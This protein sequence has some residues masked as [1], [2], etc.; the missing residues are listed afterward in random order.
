LYLFGTRVEGRANT[1]SDLDIGILTGP[2]VPLSR[3]W[4]LEDDWTAQWPET[5][6]LR[7][8]NLAPLP[9]RYQVTANGRRLWAADAGLVAG[10]ESLI[11]RQYWDNRPRLEQNWQQYVESIMEQK[12][13]A[14]RQQYQASLA[15][16]RTVH[17]RVREASARYAGNVQA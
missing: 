2:T 1:L 17:H 13:E 12:N 4:R 3:L 11:W 5:V 14:E 6:D 15:K 8:L 10:I 9:F 7:L 16:V